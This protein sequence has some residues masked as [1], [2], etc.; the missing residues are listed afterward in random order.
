MLL[1]LCTIDA[2]DHNR[3]ALLH[4]VP[5]VPVAAGADGKL[6]AAQDAAG[7]EEVS[8]S[9]RHTHRHTWHCLVCASDA[10]H[11]NAEEGVS[12]ARMRVMSPRDKCCERECEC[13]QIF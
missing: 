11:L 12:G 4:V 10:A 8:H 5:S 3:N 1:F 9:L 2:I 13:D 7:D 6:Y